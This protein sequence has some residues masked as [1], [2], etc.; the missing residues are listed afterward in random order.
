MKIIRGQPEVQPDEN[1]PPRYLSGDAASPDAFGAGFAR[2]QQ[3]SGQGLIATG[4]Q[5]F[6]IAQIQ[7]GFKNETLAK[8]ADIAATRELLTLQYDPNSGFMAK[9]G[10]NAVDAY[11]D[12]LQS[13]AEI[14]R[15]W[16]DELPNEDAKKMFDS[17]F[18]RRMEYSME[19]MASHASRE[20]VSW[21]NEASKAREASLISE[22]AFNWNDLNRFSGVTIPAIA[23]EV[24]SRGQLN[25]DAPEKIKFDVQHAI[26]VAHVRRLQAMV[27]YNPLGA[28]R[29]LEQVGPSLSGDGKIAAENAVLSGLR[30]AHEQ[31]VWQEQAQT[32]A[33]QQQNEKISTEFFSA[34]VKGQLDFNTI[35][36]SDLT[37]DKKIHWYGLVNAQIRAGDKL[38]NNNPVVV[39]DTLRRI[40][41]P[42]G[43][44]EKITD[45]TDVY[46]LVGKG[47]SLGA[48]GTMVRMI[49]DQRTPEGLRLS[50]VRNRA[51]V[52]FRPQFVQD[53]ASG[54]DIQGGKDFF[55]FQQAVV[56]REDKLRQ[57]KKDPYLLYNPNSPEYIGH[58]IPIY[59][60]TFRERLQ[61]QLD[62]IR[63][64]GS[65]V[66][67]RITPTLPPELL[68]REGESITDYLR[69]TQ[70]G[71]DK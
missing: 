9:Q 2:S 71:D 59:K 40:N 60:K 20:N 22:G 42:Y 34:L 70:R 33:R 66:S 55:E 30:L 24:V 58:L 28:L 12:T 37:S 67:G 49:V 35:A 26:D 64:G 69:R 62:S 50:E 61:R 18:T 15:K 45:I 11:Q 36:Q 27:P 57:E 16:L 25:G 51:F 63:G 7:Q 23:S 65:S 39:A 41:L 8:E 6:K 52:N 17:A 5:L 48:A 47:I 3:R 1:V 32:K 10:R 21:M 68:R 29:E 31:Q 56:A 14:R 46:A 13:A 53:S 4:E 43:S 44:P 38:E 54:P 19:R